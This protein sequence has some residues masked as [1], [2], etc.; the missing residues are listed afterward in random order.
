[1][2]E[3]EKRICPLMSNSN[4][5][6]YCKE[7]RCMFWRS[8]QTRYETFQQCILVQLAFTLDAQR[9]AIEEQVFGG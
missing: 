1:M 9:Q 8:F 2:I 3:G 5:Y 6:V 4:E 7:G